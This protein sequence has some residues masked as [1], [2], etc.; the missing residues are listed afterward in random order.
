MLIWAQVLLRAY[1]SEVRSGSVRLKDPVAEHPGVI[2]SPRMI[3]PDTISD[4][5]L[6]RSYG[7]GIMRLMLPSPLSFEGRNHTVADTVNFPSVGA[8][9]DHKL[10][11]YH[12]GTNAGL[13]LPSL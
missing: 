3:L 12:A 7:M 10:A 13:S 4:G 5:Q 9:G 11:L 8:S 1:E 2:L 6:E